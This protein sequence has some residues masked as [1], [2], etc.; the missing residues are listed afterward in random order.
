MRAKG[1]NTPMSM[2][3]LG[4]EQ[5]AKRLYRYD[6]VHAPLAN[7]K[8]FTDEHVRQ[9]RELGFV[10]IE[11]FYS[12][13]EVQDAKDALRFL[14]D[15]GNPA[16]DGVQF[17]AAAEGKQLTPEQKESYVRKIM[18]FVEF[19]ARLQHMCAHPS[20]MAIVE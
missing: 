11:N 13:A 6:R 7:P 19:D 14:I 10:A 8:Q 4:S 18:S 9:F 1:R 12:P 16:Y 3:M 2:T 5:I 17:E 20:L 15:G